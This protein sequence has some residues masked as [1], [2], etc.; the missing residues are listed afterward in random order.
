MV[1]PAAQ[2]APPSNLMGIATCGSSAR[3]RHMEVHTEQRPALRGLGLARLALV[4]GI[5]H[6]AVPTN[7]PFTCLAFIAQVHGGAPG[8]GA[9]AGGLEAG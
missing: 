2:R 9:G 6:S 1:R 3:L 5:P 7:L 4:K 8:A